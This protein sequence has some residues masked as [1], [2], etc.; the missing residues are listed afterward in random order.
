METR[1]DCPDAMRYV[2]GVKATEAKTKRGSRKESIDA[3]LLVS[4]LLVG[5][6]MAESSSTAER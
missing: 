4:M 5:S 2:V 3:V 1:R 6:E